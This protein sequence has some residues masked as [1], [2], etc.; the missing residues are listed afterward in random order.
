MYCQ[1]FEHISLVVELREPINHLKSK[2]TETPPVQTKLG[3]QTTISES[4]TLD[5]SAQPP[6]NLESI[7]SE[8]DH[9]T[10]QFK[11]QQKVLK[12]NRM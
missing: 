4:S 12:A 5:D 2:L 3:S 7:R 8:L 1:L 6:I 11:N 10:L 9:L